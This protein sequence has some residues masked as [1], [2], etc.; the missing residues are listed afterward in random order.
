ML[1]FWLENIWKYLIIVQFFF[2]LIEQNV[3]LH[4][5]LAFKWL[6]YLKFM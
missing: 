5:S 4:N 3:F 2:K 1:I 6:L